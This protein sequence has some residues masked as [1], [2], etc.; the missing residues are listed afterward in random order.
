MS[1]DTAMERYLTDFS[2]DSIVNVRMQQREP[3]LAGK[4]C[5]RSD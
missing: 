2:Q 1:L 3:G 4:P 5:T